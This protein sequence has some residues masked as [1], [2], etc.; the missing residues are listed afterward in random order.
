MVS[1]ANIRAQGGASPVGSI[2]P[3]GAGS[4][5]SGYLACDG[6]AV[7]RSTYAAL[8]SVIGTTYGSGDGSTTFNLPNTSG[9]FLRGQG[10]QVISGKTF[11]GGS[12]GNKQAD[13]TSINGLGISTVSTP[14]L[15]LANTDLTHTHSYT[16]LTT[17]FTTAAVNSGINGDIGF[18]AG[19]NP[20]QASEADTTSSA[21]GAHSHTI[22]PSITSVVTSLSSAAS[23][24]RPA[25]LTMAFFIKF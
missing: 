21:L 5:P 18:T 6:S 1:L 3:F 7:S 9:L 17:S 2:A 22:T 14:S 19:Y 24:T 10:S 16:D 4:A 13:G 12:V 11:N 20:F 23:Q 8:F 15:S 25:H